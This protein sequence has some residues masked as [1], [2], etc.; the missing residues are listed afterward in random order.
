MLKDAYRHLPAPVRRAVLVRRRARLWMTAGIVFVHV[1]KAAGTSINEALY[2]RFMGHPR[3]TDIRRWAPRHIQALPSFSVVRNP[4]SRLVSAYQFVKRG[5][6][7][8]E[9]FV[10]RIWNHQIYQVPEFSDFER[11]VNEWLMPRDV[12]KLDGVF[13]PQSLFICDRSNAPLVDHIGRFEDLDLTIKYIAEQ[14][15][16]TVVF[17]H[18]NRSGGDIDYRNFYTPS[19]ARQVGDIYS[20]DIENFKYEF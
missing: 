20:I 1:P 8:G 10:A 2:G 15:G 6:G 18:A 7:S 3:A 14:T 17:G 12:R 19:L 13:Q 11:F 16:R 5:R 4:W 9:S